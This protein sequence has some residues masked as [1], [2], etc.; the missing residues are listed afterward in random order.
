MKIMKKQY[1]ARYITATIKTKGEKITLL[2]M[3]PH[4]IAVSL[5]CFE[6]PCV[7]VVL[8]WVVLFSPVKDCS[9]LLLYCFVLSCFGM[10]CIVLC[11]L[12]NI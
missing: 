6:L 8:W 12:L 9:G 10:G 2:F 3:R 5:Y 11:C 7:V 1:G 4:T